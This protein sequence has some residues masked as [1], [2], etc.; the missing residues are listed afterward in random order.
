MVGLGSIIV[1]LAVGAI[2]SLA[3][4]AAITGWYVTLTKPWFNPP[5]WVFAPVWTILYILMGLSLARLLLA[6]HSRQRF[7][8]LITFGGQLV[9]NLLWSPLFFGAHAIAAALV[10]IMVLW[11]GI[12]ATI[13]YA[14]RV[15]RTAA[16]LLV[17]YILWVSFALML[18]AALWWLN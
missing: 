14:W 4:A 5:S 11:L 1:C 9:F 2:G 17:P 18:N 3:T 8:A 15:D 13:K 6:R 12:A 10:V 7:E 16:L